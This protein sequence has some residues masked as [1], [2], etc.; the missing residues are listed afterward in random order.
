MREI[1]DFGGSF[2]ASIL[3]GALSILIMIA[4]I[5]AF[6]VTG[7]DRTRF[8]PFWDWRR[9][10]GTMLQICAAMSVLAILVILFG[11]SIGAL[12]EAAC[13]GADDFEACM[14]GDE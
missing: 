14:E 9:V 12:S 1:F 8:G 13:R 7:S 11:T 6:I 2:G 4:P 10:G 5:A 3:M